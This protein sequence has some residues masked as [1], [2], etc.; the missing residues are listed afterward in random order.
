MVALLRAYVYKTDV[1]MRNIGVKIVRGIVKVV[2]KL[3]L[4]VHYWFAGFITWVLPQRCGDDQSRQIL[5]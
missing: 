2:G 3:P 4:K 5:P 1:I